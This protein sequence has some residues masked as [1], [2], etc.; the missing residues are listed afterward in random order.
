MTARSWDA[1][2]T[3]SA[4]TRD[5]T[6]KQRAREIAREDQAPAPQDQLEC[7]VFQLASETYAIETRYVREVHP[8]KD[9]TP[10]PCTPSFVLG[11]INVR[12]QLCPMVEL[13][14]LLGAPARGLTNATRAVI[15]H[16]A[17]MEFGIVAD[18]ILGVRW[19][20]TADILP[21]PATLF[22]VDLGFL[23]GFTRDQV[24]ILD[25]GAILAHPGIVVNE[26]VSG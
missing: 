4:A 9:L 5:A 11:V 24:V 8:L 12:G 1:A 25:A 21:A 26:E 7:M 10:I 19:V 20:E 22:G 3:P 16:D 13:K 14:H 6:L 17:T 2:A 23:R 18:A 15:I